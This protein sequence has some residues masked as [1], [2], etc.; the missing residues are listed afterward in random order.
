MLIF[1]SGDPKLKSGSVHPKRKGF[2]VLQVLSIHDEFFYCFKACQLSNCC[3]C[4]GVSS[5]VFSPNPLK[6]LFFSSTLQPVNKPSRSAFPLY[7][8]LLRG[9]SLDFFPFSGD[10]FSVFPSTLPS[11]QG[12]RTL[13]QLI[14]WTSGIPSKR[15]TV[16]VQINKRG[17]HKR[18]LDLCHEA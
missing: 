16:R 4:F 13:S 5:D 17:N 6:A 15:S 10:G 12:W 9:F 14:E 1:R 18:K 2:Q 11:A 7:Q 8:L 3:F